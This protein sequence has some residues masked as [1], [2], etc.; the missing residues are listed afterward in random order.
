MALKTT[1]RFISRL[2]LNEQLGI[3]LLLMLA[4]YV[5]NITAMN[6]GRV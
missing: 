3:A 4:C 6:D 5:A 2:Q 1:H